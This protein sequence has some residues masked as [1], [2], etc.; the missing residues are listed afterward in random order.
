MRILLMLG[1]LLL[2]AS[3]S[4][5]QN[6]FIK[7]DETCMDRYE[8]QLGAN[9]SGKGFITYHV[10]L[11]NGAKVILEVG[12]ESI[13][14]RKRLPKG[15]KSCKNAGFGQPMV[16]R[17]NSK[18]L[19]VYMVRKVGKRYN[20][21]P[22]G[23]AAYVQEVNGAISY[24]TKSYNFDY[25]RNKNTTGQDLANSSS[26]SEVYLE[27][28]SPYVCNSSY[29]FRKIPRL[30]CYAYTDIIY[31]P[32]VGIVEERTGRTVEEAEKNK[33]KLM[34]INGQPFE[35][36][37]ANVVCPRPQVSEP[38]VV[39]APPTQP[40]EPAF[41][42]TEFTDKTPTVSYG[43]I[44]RNQPEV[45]TE[46]TP[47]ANSILLDKI[48]ERRVEFVQADPEYGVI[49][50]A[51]NN[52]PQSFEFT[53]KVAVNP[54]EA[55][56]S[57]GVHVVQRE[58][59]LY[60]ISRLYGASVDQLRVW[61]KL[62]NQDLIYPCMQLYIIPP[63]TFN[64][65][66]AQVEEPKGDCAETSFAGIHIVQKGE[67]LYGIGRQYGLSISDLRKW[68]NLDNINQLSPCMRV[69]T[70]QP[71]QVLPVTNPA[72]NTAAEPITVTTAPSNAPTFD[73]LAAKGIE[74]PGVAVVRPGETLYQIARANNLNV[75]DLRSWNKLRSDVL[76]PGQVLYTAAPDTTPQPYEQTQGRI[77]SGVKANAVIVKPGESLYTI[78][79]ANNVTIQNL[80]DWNNLSSDVLKS[81]QVLFIT[82]PET[83][84]VTTTTSNFV[85][86][87]KGET[88]YQ[89]A[90][91]NNLTVANLRAW[92]NLKSDQ[93]KPGQIIYIV[94]PSVPQSFD[95]TVPLTTDKNVKVTC[96]ESSRPGVH[97]VQPGE[98]L[99]KISQIHKLTVQQL[100]GWN[101]L[102]A[103][104][105]LEPCTKLVTIAPQSVMPQ[106]YDVT[107]V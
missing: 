12:P 59:T 60:G 62:G 43:W 86:V 50:L 34:A 29:M 83:E 48:G 90:Q 67:T 49:A 28:T 52:A 25:D 46:R 92:N 24:R 97:V 63:S 96:L 65:T 100:Q 79:V 14:N 8:Y 53:E 64:P 71:E 98:T 58:E 81:G 84:V 77:D 37:Y 102:Q 10:K 15:V 70:A 82:A 45:L 42:P 4:F 22:V 36:Y 89:I 31:I 18:Q 23:L 47:Q 103:G 106:S 16:D 93:L 104:D 91:D 9:K 11:D 94:A 5:S 107:T 35:Q 40:A 61:N 20:F 80:R 88:L 19:K 78:A 33:L 21:S 6:I 85:T 99:Y 1:A 73:D 76:T 2:A 3:S 17:I 74:V 56:K 41:V 51:N 69:A 39:M 57:T 66:V 30:V 68:N 95:Q 44:A 105:V 54:C 13:R 38:A 55:P 32:E 7:Y 87:K 27:G 72:P 26:N 101:R 75:N